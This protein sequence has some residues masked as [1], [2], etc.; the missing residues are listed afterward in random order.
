MPR[1]NYMTINVH[2]TV[3]DMFEEFV[4]R[5]ELTK[6]VALNDMLEMYMLAKDEPLYLE[7]KRK[8][9]NID[10]M[11]Q[12]LADRDAEDGEMTE[13]LFIF[14]RLGFTKDNQEKEYG[15]HETMATYIADQKQR[16][17]TWF[18]TEAHYY[19]MAKEKVNF[20]NKA[21]KLGKK[22]TMLFAIGKA[23][24]GQ[25][26]IAY[27]A[28]VLEVVSFKEPTTIEGSDYPEVWHGEKARVWVKI[29][30]LQ[31]ESTLTAKMFHFPSTGAD[32]QQVINNSQCHFGYVN[33]KSDKE[34]A[35]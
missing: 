13:E 15:G 32:L 17:F 2:E 12:L 9:L 21:I 23:A 7:L 28:N 24:G 5:R 16:G 30:N 26:D 34:V 20:Y 29:E 31:P 18:S 14:M 19:G 25:N 4:E 22:V 11:K 1:K 3:Q 6:T 35:K 10:A 33:I 27:K 8:H